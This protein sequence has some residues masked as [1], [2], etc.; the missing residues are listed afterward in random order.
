MC[1]KLTKKSVSIS[2]VDPRFFFERTG[3]PCASNRACRAVKYFVKSKVLFA[4]IEKLPPVSTIEIIGIGAYT[5]HIESRISS[6]Y[7][8]LWRTPIYVRI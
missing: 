3:I 1:C 7:P 6:E 8:V 4:V 2:F 5:N